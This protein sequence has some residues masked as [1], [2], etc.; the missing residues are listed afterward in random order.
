[1]FDPWDDSPIEDDDDD[2]EDRR[3]AKHPRGECAPDLASGVLLSD[4]LRGDKP[5]NSDPV[6]TLVR[7]NGERAVLLRRKD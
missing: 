2:D 4:L 5:D 1:M 6:P 7:F 3:P